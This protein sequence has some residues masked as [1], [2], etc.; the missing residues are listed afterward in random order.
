MRLWLWL[1]VAAAITATST[2]VITNWR[3]YPE[4]IIVVDD[5]HGIREGNLVVRDSVSVGVVTKIVID[6]QTEIHIRLSDNA[7]LRGEDVISVASPSVSPPVVRITP[8]CGVDTTLIQSGGRI[9]AGSAAREAVARL[10]CDV[11]T[12]I[13]QLTPSDA[14]RVL[15]DMMSDARD[16]LRFGETPEDP[17]GLVR[18]IRREVRALID[19]LRSAGETVTADSVARILDRLRDD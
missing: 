16:Y 9:R 6:Q 10:S 18:T 19:R 5:A 15:R 13:S 11:R 12:R 17:N 3:A 1:F 8:G 4:Y 2:V 14:V 7:F